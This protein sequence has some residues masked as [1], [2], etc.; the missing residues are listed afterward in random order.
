MQHLMPKV[1][2]LWQIVLSFR[3]MLTGAGTVVWSVKRIRRIL[4]DN[5]VPMHLRDPCALLR[6][7]LDKCYKKSMVR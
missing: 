2:W 3:N 1:T 6:I 4:D 5:G 7:P